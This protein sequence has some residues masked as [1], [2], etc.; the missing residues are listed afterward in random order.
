MSTPCLTVIKDEDGGEICVLYRHWDGYPDGHGTELKNFLK[1]KALTNGVGRVGTFNGM[2][3]L[4][5][6]LVAHFKDGPG[7]I[8]LYAPGTRDVGEEYIYTVGCR[9]GKIV[10]EVE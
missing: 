8:Y 2:H 4:A 5:A 7:R 1:G 9:G 6:A 3:C 10:A